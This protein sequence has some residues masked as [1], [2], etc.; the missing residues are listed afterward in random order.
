[1]NWVRDEAR[2][3]KRHATLTDDDRT[4]DERGDPAVGRV[5]AA[6]LS[7]AQARPSIS[8]SCSRHS[9]GMDQLVDADREIIE[10]RH[11]AGMSFK[12]HR[13]SVERTGRYA[14]ARHHARSANQ[15]TTARFAVAGFEG[16]DGP[17]DDTSGGA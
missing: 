4:F 14:L 7:T 5:R 12:R 17:T 6:G 16:R 10:L 15:R 9:D 11:H 13:R 2:R 3:R 8:A 1:M